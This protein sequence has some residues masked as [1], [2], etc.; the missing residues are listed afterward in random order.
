MQVTV[1]KDEALIREFKVAVAAAD[2]DQRFERRLSDLARTV[3]IK[4]FRPGKVPV[5]LVRK[6]YGGALKSEVLEET[7]NETSAAVIKDHGLRPALAPKLEITAPGDGGDLEF[8]LAVE[9]LPEIPA[10]E[11]GGMELERRVAEVTDEHV[12]KTLM[13][14]AEAVRPVVPIDAPRP[15]EAGDIATVDLVAAEGTPLP[16]EGDGRGLKVAVGVEGTPPALGEQL[17]GLA[18]GETRTVSIT[19]PETY[20]VAACRGQTLDYDVTLNAL[21]VRAPAVLDDAFAEKLGFSTIDEVRAAARSEHEQELSRLSRQHLKRALLDRLA[22]TAS[23]DLPPGLVEREYQHVCSQLAAKPDGGGAH[24]QGHDH[25]HDHDHA[26]CGHDHDHDH[27]NAHPHP[28]DHAHAH[29]PSEDREQAPAPAVVLTAEQERE[30][31]ALAERRVRLGLLLAEVGRQNNLK[32][33]PEELSRAVV[34]EARRYPGQEH[35]VFEYFRNNAQAREALAAPLLED[36]VVDFMLELARVTE[37]RVTAEE[38][39]AGEDDGASA[40]APDGAAT[41]PG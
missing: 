5:A 6:K 9:L 11:L 41:T 13:R 2:L 31:R 20:A 35:A 30:Y 34:A 32:V 4:G 21:E 16:V 10:P 3:S 23:F 14:I 22:E 17:T 40:L 25:D 8:T 19:F 26:A 39:L 12:E 33:S 24:G 18:I 37:T 38:L 15:A 28:H 29:E 7:I 1:T 27:E 36:K